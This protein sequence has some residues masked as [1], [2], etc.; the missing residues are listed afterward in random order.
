MASLRPA[1]PHHGFWPILQL[2]PSTNLAWG[3]AS[4]LKNVFGEWERMPIAEA[5]TSGKRATSDSIKRLTEKSSERESWE[6]C[7]VNGLAW[8]LAM[9]V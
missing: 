7:E 5:V 1:V 2:L 8:R 6:R 4:P 3:P 9:T